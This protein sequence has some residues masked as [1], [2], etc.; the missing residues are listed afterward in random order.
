MT[1]LVADQRW[2]VR[3][4][5]EGA[6]LSA[7]ADLSYL[8]PELTAAEAALLADF[9]EPSPG[10]TTRKIDPRRVPDAVRQVLPQLRTLGALR[11]ADL[12]TGPRL[13]TGLR[14]AGVELPEFPSTVDEDPDLVVVVRTTGT[15]RQVARIADELTVPHLLLDLSYHH[16]ASIGPLVVPGASACL[17]CLA[18]RVGWR[19]GDEQPPARPRATEDLTFPAALVRHA[20]RR[21]GEGSLALLERIVSYD[22]DELTSTAE[23]VLPSANCPVCPHQPVGRTR[24]PWEKP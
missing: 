22:L 8:L 11:P 20:V 4:A 18:V 1:T 13:R 14:W 10:G 19:W 21:I 3:S 5:P 16:R 23:Q 12:P 6:V 17:A 9:F 24:L 7:G 2:R 15:W